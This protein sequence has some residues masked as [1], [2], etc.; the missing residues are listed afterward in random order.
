M[1]CRW[2]RPPRVSRR[3]PIPIMERRQG[4]W[5]RL[6]KQHKPLLLPCACN[7]NRQADSTE[8]FSC[9]SSYRPPMPKL[10]DAV[11]NVLNEARILL[12]GGQVL[13]GFS[14]RIA[15]SKDLGRFPARAVR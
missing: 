4:Q 15:L 2:E 3:H 8:G 7:P 14:F 1:A 6:L 12:L 9:Q 10:D 5:K 13:L 11:E